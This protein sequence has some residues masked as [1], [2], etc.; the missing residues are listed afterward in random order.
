[1]SNESALVGSSLQKK[2]MRDSYQVKKLSIIGATSEQNKSS[3]LES[4]LV[5]GLKIASNRKVPLC[6][7]T[8]P[9]WWA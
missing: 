5:R 7:K 4:R 9:P 2:G 6:Q 3:C 1:M 8:V